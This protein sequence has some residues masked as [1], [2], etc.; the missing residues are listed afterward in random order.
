M[1]QSKLYTKTRK[2]APKDEVSK[3]AQLLIRAGYIFKEMAGVYTILPLGYLVLEKIVKIVKEE[4]AIRSQLLEHVSQRIIHRIFNELE[5]V[6][7]IK[8]AVSKLN[9]PIGGNVE[10]VSIKLKK[11]R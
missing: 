6:L 3:N 5:S 1:R 8:I 11:K 7:K 4:M 10:A 2:E 9:P